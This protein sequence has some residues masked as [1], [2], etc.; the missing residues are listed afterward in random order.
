MKSLEVE[1]R[2][3]LLKVKGSS[4]DHFVF[5]HL[6]PD[7]SVTPCGGC[8][9]VLNV[10]QSFESLK[11]LHNLSCRGIV[12]RDIRLEKEIQYLRGRNVFVLDFA[13]VENLF[14][15]EEVLRI[16]AKELL[17]PGDGVIRDVKTLVLAELARACHELFCR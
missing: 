4:I 10:T 11:Q 12:D 5:S 9:R 6:Y 15:L 1:N 8:G 13:E 3:Y 2:F 7:W 17:I 16:A 14:L